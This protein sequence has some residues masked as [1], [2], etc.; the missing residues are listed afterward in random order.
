[1]AR[2]M[3]PGYIGG[4]KYTQTGKYTSKKLVKKRAKARQVRNRI[5]VP[6][7][8]GF[9]KRMTMTLRYA[10][11][12]TITTA[13]SGSISTFNFRANS[14]FDPNQTGVGHQPMYFDQMM[15]IYNHYIVIGSKITITWAQLPDAAGTRPPVI[16]GCFL[17]D[18]T[19]VTPGIYGILENSTIKS[20]TMTQNT[21]VTCTTVCKFSA[22][23]NFGG[24]V[25]ADADLQG[26]VTTGP[27]EEMIYTLFVDSS[28]SLT[29]CTV[30][31]NVRI[32]YIA[33]FRELKDLSTS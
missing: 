17:N 8:L 21:G 20:K 6:V 5:A 14:L 13:G 24:S 9:P 23:K 30:M 19:V 3:K 11:I 25:L 10:D 12:G 16:V 1:M 2:T 4:R 31:Y 27:A 7:G 28:P 22:K 32:D 33:V 15:A 18:D 29:S 26:T